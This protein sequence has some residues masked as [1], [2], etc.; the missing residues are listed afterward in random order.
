MGPDLRRAT[1]AVRPG[2]VLGVYLVAFSVGTISHLVD[3]LH[4]GIRPHNQY[5][6]AFNLFWTEYLSTG[7]FLMWGLY[8]QVPFALFLLATAPSLWSAFGRGEPP[9]DELQR[10]RPAQAMEPRR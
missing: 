10:T 1:P 8:T 4:G 9:N 5:H 3:I 6:W 7:R 2:L